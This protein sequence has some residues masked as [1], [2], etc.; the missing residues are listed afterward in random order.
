MKKTAVRHT[1]PA[2]LV[3]GTFALNILSLALPIMT[4]Q[5]YDRILPNPDSGTLPLLICGV[6][7]AIMIETCLRIARAWMMGWNGAVYEHRLAGKAMNHILAADI[8]QTTKTGAGGFLHRMSAISRLKDFKNGYVCV[9]MTELIFVPVFLGLIIYIAAPLAFIPLSLLLIFTGISSMQG[10]RIREELKKREQADDIRYDFM[11]DCLNGIHTLKSFALEHLLARRYEKLQE[12]SG[13][14]S[15]RTA[16]AST[17]A[18][19]TGTMLSHIMMAAVIS[20]GAIAVV[21]GTITTGALIATLQL[22]GRLMQPVQRAL[23]LWTRYQDISIARGKVQDIFDLPAY[24]RKNTAELPAPSGRIDAR[25]LSFGTVLKDISLSVGQGECIA[26]GG[27]AGSGKTTLMEILAGLYPADR[28]ELILDGAPIDQYPMPQL[29]RHIGYLAS[30]AS[31]FRGTIRDNITCFGSIAEADAQ[32]IARML[33]V[34]RDVAS[35]PQG[36]DTM[37]QPGSAGII[38]P[39]LRQRIA[40]TRTL[41]S[42]PKIILFDEADRAL[43]RDGYNL[44]FSL[45]GRL[46]GKATIIIASEDSNITALADRHYTLQDGTLLEKNAAPERKAAS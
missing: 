32:S 16:E 10:K 38:P 41:A 39:G 29:I 15:F 46:R 44:V 30:D 2:H 22:S 40:L 23:A 43:D 33:H 24:H 11:I 25:N 18:F 27:P 3:L 7:I 5:I 20:F 21:G 13:F 17:A 28:G 6:I 31:V 1:E 37:L 12:E 9:T 4:L 19:N 26:I 36:F 35:L 45:M 8:F 34:D 42:R 14:A